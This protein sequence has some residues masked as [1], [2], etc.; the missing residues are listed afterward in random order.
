MGQTG[1]PILIW[2][3][4][5]GCDKHVQELMW[6]TL[7]SLYNSEKEFSEAYFFLVLNLIFIRI[8]RYLYF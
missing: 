3:F 5:D 4:C 7:T 8:A 1:W 6:F 2:V